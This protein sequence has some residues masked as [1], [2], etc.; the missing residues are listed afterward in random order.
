M[1]CTAFP[2]LT[3]Q[4]KRAAHL[5]LRLPVRLLRPR[6]GLPLLVLPLV[7]LALRPLRWR[8]TCLR[9]GRLRPRHLCRLRLLSLLVCLPVA[10]AAAGSGSGSGRLIAQSPWS[11][12]TCASP[13]GSRQPGSSGQA[14][15]VQQLWLGLAKPQCRHACATRVQG[16]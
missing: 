9:L 5:R 13:V 3:H 1:Q 4:C 14:T 10:L 7:V 2:A 8:L 12:C 6:L 16:V 15:V 11:R